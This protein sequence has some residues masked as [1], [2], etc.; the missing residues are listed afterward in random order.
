VL[1]PVPSVRAVVAADAKN[2][3]PGSL[4]D[5]GTQTVVE[6]GDRRRWR[7]FG[8]AFIQRSRYARQVQIGRV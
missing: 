5:N 8:E 1:Q 3:G 6:E 2:D 4:D 7:Y